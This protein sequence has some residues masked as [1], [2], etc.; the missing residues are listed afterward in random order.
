M[1]TSLKI[2]LSAET[3]ISAL[4]A[5]LYSDSP[6]RPTVIAKRPPRLCEVACSL[7]ATNS[8]CPGAKLKTRMPA[9]N[10]NRPFVRS[11][12]DSLRSESA[13]TFWIIALAVDKDLN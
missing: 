5:F 7:P 11:Y 1:N 13:A 9:N 4:F 6:I 3:P 10:T 2:M 12:L 8:G